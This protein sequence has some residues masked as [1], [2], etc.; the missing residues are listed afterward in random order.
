MRDRK[1]VT[2]HMSGFTQSLVPGGHPGVAD[3]GANGVVNMPLGIIHGVERSVAE[4]EGRRIAR[5]RWVCCRGCRDIRRSSWCRFSFRRSDCRPSGGTGLVT[6]GAWR[7]MEASTA[8]M[9][10]RL[11]IFGGVESAFVGKKPSVAM[12]RPPRKRRS[13]VTMMPR[14]KLRILTSLSNA[15]LAVLGDAS[16]GLSGESRDA[17]WRGRPALPT[18]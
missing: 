6:R 10:M 18:L 9:A 8:D 11:S 1:A 17:G 12:A 16:Y 14:M 7:S 5:S 13:K 2:F 4:P 15:S 3:A